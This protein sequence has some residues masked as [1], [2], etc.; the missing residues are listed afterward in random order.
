MIGLLALIILFFFV[1]ELLEYGL[2]PNV[3]FAVAAF[4]VATLV[5]AGGVKRSRI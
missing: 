5:I 4:I 2:D 1:Q 3:I